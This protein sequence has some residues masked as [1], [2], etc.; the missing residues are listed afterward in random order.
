MCGRFFEAVKDWAKIFS[1]VVIFMSLV[2]AVIVTPRTHLFLT[3]RFAS[4]SQV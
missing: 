4:R 3:I 2:M 1:L